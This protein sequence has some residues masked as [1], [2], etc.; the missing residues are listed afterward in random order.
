M[1][2]LK[3]Q[4]STRIY[5]VAS[6]LFVFLITSFFLFGILIFPSSTFANITVSTCQAL[7]VPNTTY[8]IIT[9]LTS[10]GDCLYV[11]ASGITIDGGNHTINGNI[12]SSGSLFGPRASALSFQV[13]SVIL[14]GDV[15]A[16][17]ADSDS[18]SVYGGAGGNI[19]CC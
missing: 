16:D 10:S 8:N 7:S 14:N 11:I 9:D 3:P 19:I 18:A 15:N 17:G 4:T 2:L 12:T 1:P 5:R 6:P 13:R